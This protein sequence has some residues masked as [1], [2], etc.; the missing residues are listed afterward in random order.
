M[1]LLETMEAGIIGILSSYICKNRGH[2]SRLEWFWWNK[3]GGSLNYTRPGWHEELIVTWKTSIWKKKLNVV[4]VVS[5][6][7]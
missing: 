1:S 2:A 7:L 5:C 6:V 3:I 4:D